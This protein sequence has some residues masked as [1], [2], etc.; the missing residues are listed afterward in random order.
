M[1]SY[2][3]GFISDADIYAHVKATIESY[4]REIDL[5]QFNQNIIDPIK[6]SFDCK[7]YGKT[8]E[9]AIQ[10][11]CIRQ[12]DKSNTNLI[13]YFH[14]RLFS[15]LGNGWEVPA[16]GF[17]VE[18]KQK[19]IFAEMKNKHNTMNSSSSQKTYIKMQHKLLSD[20]QAVCYLVEVIARKSQDIPWVTTVDKVARKHNKIR[21]IS[22]DKF[23]ELVV[24]DPLAFY[25]LCVALPKIIDDVVAENKGLT[26]SSSVYDEL[27]R[28]HADILTALYKLAF[29]TYE[30]FA[31]TPKP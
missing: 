15:Y 8:M 3:L 20:D 6:M 12:I 7:V 23:Y 25:K 17:D 2:N 24:G 10:D 19:H 4:R 9:E 28:E 14:Q 26:I 27:V 11:E 29:K 5:E 13:G 21:R 1:H 22:I 16:K 18:N 30:G 31:E